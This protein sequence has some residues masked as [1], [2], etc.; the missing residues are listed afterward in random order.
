VKCVPEGGEEVLS[1]GPAVACVV[2]EWVSGFPS[3]CMR[4]RDRRW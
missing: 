4:R 2:L 1:R 3:A